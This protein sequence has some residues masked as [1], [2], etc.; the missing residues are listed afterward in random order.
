MKP[1]DEIRFILLC[2]GWIAQIRHLSI[3]QTLDLFNSH[4]LIENYILPCF[5]ILKNQSPI[6]IQNELL[7]ILNQNEN[8]LHL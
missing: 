5:S 8:N 7:A 6:T 1:M 4:H 3:N 2:L